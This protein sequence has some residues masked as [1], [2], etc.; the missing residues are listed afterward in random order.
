MLLTSKVSASFY[1]Y[2]QVKL[3]EEI[4]LGINTLVTSTLSY[5]RVE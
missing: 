4:N 3:T 5:L 2:N 1:R